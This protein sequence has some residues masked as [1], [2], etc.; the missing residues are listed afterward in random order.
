MVQQEADNN[1][2]LLTGVRQ[3]EQEA[4]DSAAQSSPL[5]RI[6]TFTMQFNR[7]TPS[8][9]LQCDPREEGTGDQG[10]PVVLNQQA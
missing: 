3:A 7:G 2:N 5:S 8:S 6:R 9:G 10:P 4:S 1:S